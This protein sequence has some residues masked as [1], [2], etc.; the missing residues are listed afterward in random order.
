HQ[1]SQLLF[2]V[3]FTRKANSLPPL[4]T[5]FIYQN[6]GLPMPNSYINIGQ[7]MR[8][9]GQPM[10]QPHPVDSSIYYVFTTLNS[11]LQY[12]VV[13]M[14]LANGKGDI[15]PNQ[16]LIQLLPQGSIIATKTTIISGCNEN[17]LLVR[18]NE[19]NGYY[20]YKINNN[21][22]HP[23]PIVYTTGSLTEQSYRNSL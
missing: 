4:N 17:W 12:S 1:T 22:L 6:N 10:I 3:H 23:T 20:S 7:Y 5:P 8:I 11:G 14:R 21:G 18:S 9:H 16:K 15:V 2:F 13:D 19:F